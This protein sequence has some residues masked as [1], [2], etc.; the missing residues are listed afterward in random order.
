MY[1]ERRWGSY[2]VIDDTT[3]ADGRHSLTKSLTINA[4]KN[5]S[6]Q[7]H[8]HRSEA[9]TIVEGEG[10]LVLDGEERKIAA[11]DIVSIP[12]GH[13]HALKALTTLTFIEVQT[14][15]PLIEEDIE[16]ADW[17]WSE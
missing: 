4:G 11:G 9:W 14:G 6:Y 13:W 17:T 2:R 12:V 16:R 8:R 10:L 3:Y 15:N 1:E 7:V 5:I